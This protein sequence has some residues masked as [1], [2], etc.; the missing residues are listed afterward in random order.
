MISL[1]RQSKISIKFSILTV[2][3][4]FLF[5]I[6]SRPPL[7]HTLFTFC[8]IIFS[9]I[10]KITLHPRDNYIILSTKYHFVKYFRLRLVQ[11]R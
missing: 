7:S 9:P 4:V 5:L 8:T 10:E 1:V 11:G 3:F 6:T 2:P